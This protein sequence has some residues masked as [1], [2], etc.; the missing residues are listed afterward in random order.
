MERANHVHQV[1]EP[2]AG[3]ADRGLQVVGGIEAVLEGIAGVDRL[4]EDPGAA[5]VGG[6]A[7]VGAA[8]RQ[9]KQG[10]VWVNALL[11]GATVV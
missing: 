4:D 7:P 2:A 9:V 6:E 11:V 5:A 1:T 8:C 10:V 3:H